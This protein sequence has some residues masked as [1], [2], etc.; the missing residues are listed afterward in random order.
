MTLRPHAVFFKRQAGTALFSRNDFGEGGEV[1]AARACRD[2][3]DRRC[4]FACS[5]YR[6]RMGFRTKRARNAASMQITAEK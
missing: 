4:Y 5:M 6:T 3:L 1:R 2:A